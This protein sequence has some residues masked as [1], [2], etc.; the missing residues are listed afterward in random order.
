MGLAA[1][2]PRRNFAS[3]RARIRRRMRLWDK[4]IHTTA[5]SMCAALGE[6]QNKRREQ[7]I[8]SRTDMRTM[9]PHQHLG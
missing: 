6:Q 5:A 2:E 8:G 7:R 3:D 9:V 4:C 1:R